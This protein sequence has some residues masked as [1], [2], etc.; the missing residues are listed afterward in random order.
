VLCLQVS[1]FI[2]M[3]VTGVFAAGFYGQALQDIGLENAG[4]QPPWC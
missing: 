4:G 2:N 1:V 3:F